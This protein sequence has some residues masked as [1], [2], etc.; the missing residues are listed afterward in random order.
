M[1]FGWMLGIVAWKELLWKREKKH[2]KLVV[3]PHLRTFGGPLEERLQGGPKGFG[4]SCWELSFSPFK[5][6]IDLRNKQQQQQQ[7]QQP[8][9]TTTTTTSW[10]MKIESSF[11]LELLDVI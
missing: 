7:P 2:G 9:T 4:G 1:F 10:V 3:L 8:P 11:E 6:W 5:Q